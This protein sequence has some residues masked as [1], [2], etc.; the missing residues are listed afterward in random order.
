MKLSP[1]SK[2]SFFDRFLKLVEVTT[3]SDRLLL[4][5]L[6]FVVVF[7]GVWLVYAV[8]EQYSSDMPIHGGL[9]REGIIGT[10]RFINPALAITRADQDVSS[11]VYSGL[12]K[13]NPNGELVPDVA[14]SVTVSEDGLTYNVVLRKDVRFHDGDPL[15]ARDVLFTIQLIQNADLKS[16]LR[17]S[18]ADVTVEEVGEYELNIVLAEA[19][20]PFIENFQFGIMPAHLWSS[21]PIEQLPF[22]QLNTEPI[23]S[24]P[25][26]VVTAMRDPSGL[27]EGYTL[28]ANRDSRNAP[29]IDSLELYFYTEES[30]L[31]DALKRHT[32][33]TSAYISNENL[34]EI[35][36]TGHYKV[37]TEPLPRSF[38]IFFNQN[39]SAA[40]RDPVV[41]EALSISID[42]TRLI[43]KALHGQ[44]VPILPPV[45][46]TSDAVESGNGSNVSATSSVERAK[47]ILKDAGW[48]SNNL[49]LLEKQVDGSAETL[50]VTL[51]TSNAPLFDTIT[52][53]I[54]EEWKAIGVEVAVEQFDQTGLVQSVIRPRDFQT[55][56]FGV[57][58]SRSGDLYPFWHSSQKDDPGLNVAQYTNLSVDALLERARTEQNTETRLATL[59][60]ANDIIAREYPAVMLFQ[61]KMAY[62]VQN[63]IIVSEMHRVARPSDRFS[64]ITDWYTDSDTLWNVFKN[65]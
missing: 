45:A 51:R 20:A 62:V 33:D 55:L 9:L 29:K 57:D 15:T 22:S 19:Y 54:V 13:I 16:P 49:G 50:S 27:I 60:E 1:R 36:Q 48:I 25:F 21:I 52:Q 28:E 32:V 14:E 7:S 35:A 17:G 58:M 2:F 41:R 38:G 59:S 3:P 44:G 53:Q 24:G 5:F 8:N 18:W 30:K 4:R 64:N 40:L 61:P 12:M 63:D 43:E 11:L 26:K 47:Q 56:L 10:P 46:S 37:I 31:I 65:E 39:K 34:A 42:R 6:F 23:G